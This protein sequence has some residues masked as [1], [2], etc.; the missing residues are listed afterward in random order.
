[1]SLINLGKH[2]LRCL[3]D[4]L[5]GKKNER[6]IAKEKFIKGAKELHGISEK[7]TQDLW[8]RIEAFS[9]YGFNKSHAIAYAIDSYYGAWLHTYH[10]AEW[11]A[12]ILDSENNNPSG[13]AKTISEIKSYGY[14]I[15]DAD[16]NYSGTQWEYSTE[17]NAFVPTIIINQ[18]CRRC[19][20]E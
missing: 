16:I 18:R 2:L 3:D 7:V 10:E 12:T 15:V 14:R 13:L 20:N 4:S 11:L 6:Q 1:M 17:I 5:G 9:T 19:C 8:E